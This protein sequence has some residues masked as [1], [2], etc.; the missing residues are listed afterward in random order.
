[1]IQ[2]A[3]PFFLQQ[4]KDG[5][6]LKTSKSSPIK[7]PQSPSKPD[8]KS[9]LKSQLK[10]VKQSPKHDSHVDSDSDKKS[11]AKPKQKLSK[12][13]TNAN[14]SIKRKKT[15][16]DE[17]GSD[18]NVVT[19]KRMASLNA[20][21]ILSANYEIENYAA[22]HESSSSESSDNE[23]EVERND[24]PPT[25]KKEKKDVKMES[26]DLVSWLEV[27]LLLFVA[28]CC[29]AMEFLLKEFVELTS[30][31][32][33]RFL[34]FAMVEISLAFVSRVFFDSQPR[35]KSTTNLVKI[36]TECTITGV[37]NNLSSQETICKT[38]KY[39]VTEECVVSRP[40]TQEPPKSYTPLSALTNMRPPHGTQIPPETCKCLSN[41]C[42]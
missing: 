1:L 9:K 26:E 41:I 42:F 19:K 13:K 6:S 18:K 2:S 3:F 22:K 37:Y 21:A 14:G 32:F 4:T 36:D 5:S 10:R 17:K 8:S 35:P 20:S 30:S 29:A 28:F 25:M 33:Y 27:F 7:K 40:P 15:R 12:K 38:L 31:S 24:E 34:W 16:D 39:R 11:T 23:G